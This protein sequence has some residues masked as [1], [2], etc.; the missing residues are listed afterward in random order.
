MRLDL[1]R[2]F[3]RKRK[4]GFFQTGAMIGSL[5]TGIFRNWAFSDIS[6]AAPSMLP[7]CFLIVSIVATVTL[8]RLQALKEIEP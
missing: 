5:L 3:A 8:Y 6:N 2:F 4:S 1:E 7:W